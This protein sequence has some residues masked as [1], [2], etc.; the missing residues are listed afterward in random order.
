METTFCNCCEEY[1]SSIGFHGSICEK[2]AIDV[3]HK[4]RILKSNGYRFCTQCS[5][6]LEIENFKPSSKGCNDCV[7]KGKIID[8]Q[9]NKFDLFSINQFL[10]DRELQHNRKYDSKAEVAK[11]KQAE[12][13]KYREIFSDFYHNILLKLINR[14]T[15]VIVLNRWLKDSRHIKSVKTSLLRFFQDTDHGVYIIKKDVVFNHDLFVDACM[16]EYHSNQKIRSKKA[17]DYRKSRKLKIQK[18]KEIENERI[19]KENE[20]KLQE[21]QDRL[22][23]LEDEQLGY[24]DISFFQSSDSKLRTVSEVAETIKDSDS[25][26]DSDSVPV[27]NNYKVLDTFSNDYASP[28]EYNQFERLNDIYE[29]MKKILCLSTEQRDVEQKRTARELQNTRSLQN[30]EQ[31]LDRLNCK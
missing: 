24:E 16:K 1:R 20:I 21:E 31:L 4:N 17:F 10:T 27:S 6:I 13:Q 7:G 19:K 12:E 2:C 29:V 23:K 14:D 8:R 25:D 30:I 11:R 15:L 5:R 3:A 28:Q 18:A 9:A 26:S 22:K